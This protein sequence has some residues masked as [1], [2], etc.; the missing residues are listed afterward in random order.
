MEKD[1]CHDSGRTL[2][3]G[4]YYMGYT[5]GDQTFVKCKKCH[6][7]DPVLRN[8]QPCEVYSRIV[9][10]IRPVSQWNVGKKLEFKD[11]VTFKTKKGEN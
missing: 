7:K 4:D 1:I 10:Y 11:R 8:F 5:F 6:K 9:G 3:K 2:K